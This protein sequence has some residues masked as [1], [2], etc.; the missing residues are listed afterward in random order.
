[1]PEKRQTLLEK[2]LVLFNQA[3]CTDNKF[4]LDLQNIPEEFKDIAKYLQG[5]L[6]DNK[7]RR[8]LEAEEELDTIFDGQEAKY[9]NQIALALDEKEEANNQKE[10]LAIK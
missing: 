2:F 7:F 1:M 6:M 9:L 3:W 5:P 4:N 8:Q 10:T